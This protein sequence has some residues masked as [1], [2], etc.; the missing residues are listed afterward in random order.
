[1]QLILLSCLTLLGVVSLIGIVILEMHTI[2]NIGVFSAIAGA[3]V[4][5][6]AGLV[7]RWGDS[8]RPL[9]A[10]VTQMQQDLQ[11][12]TRTTDRIA[13]DV[14]GNA[15][16]LRAEVASVRGQLDVA[17]MTINSMQG[18]RLGREQVADLLA[19]QQSEER[20]GLVQPSPLPVHETPLP[21]EAL[22]PD[23]RHPGGPGTPSP[24]PPPR[25]ETP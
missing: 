12:N 18:A 24:P 6:L 21:H 5:A 4:G 19:M 25:R 7:T 22:V 10:Q 13:T 1:M 11:S 9:T 16:A 23:P 20:R 15:S 14:N 2:P 8:I 3:A 17:L